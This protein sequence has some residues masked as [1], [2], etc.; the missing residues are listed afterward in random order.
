[1]SSKC[2]VIEELM[3]LLL[4]K[5]IHSKGFDPILLQK[6]MCGLSTN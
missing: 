6:E 4:F 5:N 2:R 1:M 3:W